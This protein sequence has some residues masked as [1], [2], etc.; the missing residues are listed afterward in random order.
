MK[1]VLV[2]QMGHAA[3][4]AEQSPPQGLSGKS[5]TMPRQDPSG[6][7]LEPAPEVAGNACS[8][9]EAPGIADH[10]WRLEWRPAGL[11]FRPAGRPGRRND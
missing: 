9:K 8:L 7:T 6:D 2:K 11:G 10:V 1:R 4:G 3:P 5:P